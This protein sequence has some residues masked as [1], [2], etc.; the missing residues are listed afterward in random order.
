MPKQSGFFF[1]VC[2]DAFLIQRQITAM[3]KSRFGDEGY[4]RICAWA[5][6][7]LSDKFWEQLGSQGF[8]IKPRLI[9]LRHLESLDSENLKKLS[10]TL[11]T[12]RPFV[13]LILCIENAWEKRAA[14]VPKA[15]NTLQCY[16]FAKK[17]GW[18]WTSPPLY[19]QAM[20]KYVRDEAKAHGLNFSP[21]LLDAFCKALCPE[22][23][24]ASAAAIDNELKKI[25]LFAKDGKVQEKDLS[26]IPQSM[27]FDIFAFLRAVQIKDQT[28]IWKTLKR[29]QSIGE[30]PLFL[31]LFFLQREARL[32]WQIVHNEPVWIHNSEKNVKLALAKSLGIQ[33]I[34]SL[35]ESL[36][37]AE[38]S[39]KSGFLDTDQSLER[40]LDTL[41][42]LFSLKS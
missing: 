9:I 8:S 41:S 12:P 36:T 38:L 15:I 40:L 1:C 5:D 22:G 6:E 18:I 13:W 42:E 25:A 7:G 29:L 27:G 2:P 24:E 33:G 14:K 26:L 34:A 10:L 4:E 20:P 30:N 3:A 39:V 11:A 32:Y 23:A 28:T 17:Q 19:A 16:E 37:K 35:Y 21:Q 31:L